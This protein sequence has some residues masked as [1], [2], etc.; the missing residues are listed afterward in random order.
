RAAAVSN[1]KLYCV[2]TWMGNQGE[3]DN[4]PTV[5]EAASRD[6]FSEFHKNMTLFGC[7][8]VVICRGDS[9]EIAKKWEQGSID[10]LFIDASHD[11]ESV[12]KDLR[13]WVPLVKP[14]GVICGDDWNRE[15]R[16]DLKGSVRK[17]FEDFFKSTAPNLG[18]VERFWAHQI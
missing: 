1:S 4:H 15:E 8:N 9:I 17:A 16:P 13:A 14:G 3:G 11:Y 10:F 12:L 7:D 2:D 5:I 18:I 6:I